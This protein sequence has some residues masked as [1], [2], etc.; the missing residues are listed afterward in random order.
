M[1]LKSSLLDLH[2]VHK[3]RKRWKYKF[4]CVSFILNIS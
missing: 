3:E 2:I 4:D 1:N